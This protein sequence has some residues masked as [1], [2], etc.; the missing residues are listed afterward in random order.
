[1]NETEVLDHS[2][3]TRRAI[4]T[5]GRSPNDLH[6]ANNVLNEQLRRSRDAIQ[7]MSKD[8]DFL[9][10]KLIVCVDENSR[11]DSRVRD[12]NNTI[13][14]LVAERNRIDVLL[15]VAKQESGLWQ[16]SSNFNAETANIEA[17]RNA[18]LSRNNGWT[19]LAAVIGWLATLAAGAWIVL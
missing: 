12:C 11:L 19:L 14:R 3:V 1:M 2:D 16:E 13:T 10:S 7:R 5:L 15:E 9:A 4:A 17:S 6:E 8:G 18:E